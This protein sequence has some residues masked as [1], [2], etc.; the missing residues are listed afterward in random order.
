MK[1]LEQ[2]LLQFARQ[3]NDMDTREKRELVDTQAKSYVRHVS[4]PDDIECWCKYYED[5]KILAWED[6]GK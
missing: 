1:I 5:C 2:R 6:F 4:K 3:H